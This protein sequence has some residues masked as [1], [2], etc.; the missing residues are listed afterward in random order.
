MEI[1][2]KLRIHI[3]AVLLMQ[4]SSAFQVTMPRK[5]SSFLYT[6]LLIH[7]LNYNS[8]QDDGFHTNKKIVVDKAFIVN[9]SSNDLN[10]DPYDEMKKISRQALSSVLV[11]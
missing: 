1:K 11:S 8:N 3:L 2:R 4:S 5:E 7:Q 9:A 10:Y 6:K